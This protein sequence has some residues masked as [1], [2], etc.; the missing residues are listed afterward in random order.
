MVLWPRQAYQ[1][2]LVYKLHKP[3]FHAFLFTFA[4]YVPNILNPDLAC[5]WISLFKTLTEIWRGSKATL[6]HKKKENIVPIY[7]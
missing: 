4:D 3:F 5:E 2:S 6:L 1:Q 7:F